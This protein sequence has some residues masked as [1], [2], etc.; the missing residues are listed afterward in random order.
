M[1]TLQAAEAMFKAVIQ[2]MHQQGTYPSP[3]AINLAIHN[4]KSNNLN[5]RETKWRTEEMTKLKIALKRPRAIVPKILC[6]TN[7][8]GCRCCA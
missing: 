4:R 6:Y 8:P 3:T 2:L 1:V 7:K 5:G